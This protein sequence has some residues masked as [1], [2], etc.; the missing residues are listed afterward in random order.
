DLEQ[1]ILDFLAEKRLLVILDNCEHLLEAVAHMVDTIVHRCASVSV[2]ATSREGLALDGERLIAVPS[3]HIPDVD[4]SD[5]DLVRA[6]AVQ[7]FADRARAARDDFVLS[8]G[9][10]ATVGVLCR[11]LDGIPLAIELAAAR[12]RSMSPDDLV[13]RLDQRFKLL[14]RGSRAA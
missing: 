13:A 10:V 11:R 3:L 7:L 5:D 8:G 6:E 12:V 1:F 9:T 4:A 2:L 14:T